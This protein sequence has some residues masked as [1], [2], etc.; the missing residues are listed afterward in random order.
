MMYTLQLLMSA[1]LMLRLFVF[2]LHTSPEDKSAQA[3]VK[4]FT[5]LRN[6]LDLRL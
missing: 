5:Q 6:V 1:V 2:N 3:T 4:L